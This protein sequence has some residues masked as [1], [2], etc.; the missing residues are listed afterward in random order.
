MIPD[1]LQVQ[2]G[3]KVPDEPVV[4]VVIP[5]WRPAWLEEA[6]HSVRAQTVS[7]IEIVVVDDGSPEPVAPANADDLVLARQPNG[8]AAAARNTGVDLARAPWIA[9]LDADDV[10][11]PEKLA[12]QLAFHGEHPELIASTTDHVIVRPDRRVPIDRRVRYGLTPPIIDYG[13]LFLENCLATSGLLVRREDYLAVGG[14]PTHLRF[15]EDYACWLRLGL[16]GPIGYL[17]EPL[18]EYREHATSLTAEALSDA[19][20]FTVEL[21]MYRELRREHPELSREPFVWPALARSWRDLGRHHLQGSRFG[22]A[23][24]AYLQAI[25]FGPKDGANWRGLLRAILRRAPR[26]DR[27]RQ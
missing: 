3:T 11:P 17:P 16:R 26:D 24:A 10:W 7:G 14:M 13:T 4:S 21:E 2:R 20:H 19:S 23:A 8:G 9:F 27:G 5:A 18:L 15:G 22:A 12:R 1:G 25:R 6:L